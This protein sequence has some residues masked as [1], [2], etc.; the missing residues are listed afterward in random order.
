MAKPWVAY[1]VVFG[2]IVLLTSTY[3]LIK[4]LRPFSFGD[5]ERHIYIS[6][7]A[8]DLLGYGCNFAIATLCCVYISV[9]AQMKVSLPANV[10]IIPFVNLWNAV[11]A[12][13]ILGVILTIV[14]TPIIFWANGKVYLELDT[15][16]VN[17]IKVTEVS[18]APV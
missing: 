17:Q 8:T 7:F 18:I 6:V 16:K 14:C 4:V 9:L 13:A 2:V 3:G 12:E 15:P 5:K 11:T 1:F 10:V